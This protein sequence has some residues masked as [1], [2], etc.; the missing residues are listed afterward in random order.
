M[1]SNHR[2][3]ACEAGSS[4]TRI[5]ARVSILR[6]LCSRSAAPSVHC[7][8]RV[9]LCLVHR[10]RSLDQTACSHLAHARGP[11][12]N[13]QPHSYDI[14]SRHSPSSSATESEVSLGLRNR[15]SEVRILSG[16]H[17]RACNASPFSLLVDGAHKIL[18]PFFV[19]GARCSPGSARRGW[20]HR[21]P[22]LAEQGLSIVQAPTSGPDRRRLT[23]GEVTAGP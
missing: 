23:Q 20:G 10:S 8:S 21:P 11:R 17:Q 16:A 1:V 13:P 4:Q 18:S 9:R 5:P 22:A 12:A 15:R 2:P 3:L 14:P 6:L 7:L 19:S